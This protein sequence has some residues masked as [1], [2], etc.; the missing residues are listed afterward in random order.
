MP[1][2]PE[3]SGSAS[4]H[5]R[6]P[7]QARSRKTLERIVDAALEIIEEEGVQ[8]AT[9]S[10]V[11]ERAGSSVGSFYARFE[12]KDDLLRYLEE[13][14]WREARARWE[15]ARSSQAWDELELEGV[16]RSVVRLLIRI[17]REDVG[18]RRALGQEGAGS[19][20]GSEAQRFHALVEREVATLLLRRREEIEHP[21]PE[22]AARISYRW[23][24]G[25]IR[26]LLEDGG[27]GPGPRAEKL[28]EAGGTSGEAG[29]GSLP[30]APRLTPE[31]VVDEV[32][33]GLVSYLAGSVEG[34]SDAGSVE[35]FDVWQ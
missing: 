9:V 29:D 1:D 6:A 7:Q 20:L 5:V 27:D 24:L 28:P 30:S 19:G 31:D 34:P 17:H 33:R 32:T 18:S 10:A 14:V 26:E 25:G 4:D 22:R 13:R 2:L 15:D 8:G 16:V 12:G 23:A 3:T 21:E 11:V 35:F